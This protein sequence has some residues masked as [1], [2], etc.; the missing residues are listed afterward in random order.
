MESLG[1]EA[2]ETGEVNS[3]SP[4][5]QAPLLVAR[6]FGLAEAEY[7]ANQ[8]KIPLPDTNF[9]SH[10]SPIAGEREFMHSH[11][12]TQATKLFIEDFCFFN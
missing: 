7:L 4:V 8:A 3:V 12:Y 6:L 11:T 10:Q 5:P 2:V 9:N 1:R